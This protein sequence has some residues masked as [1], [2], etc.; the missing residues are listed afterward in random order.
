MTQQISRRRVLQGAGA[1]AL[2]LL[3][4]EGRPAA[5]RASTPASLRAVYHMT[6]PSGWL[7]DPQRPV[8]ADGAYQL[9]YLHSGQNNG[10]GG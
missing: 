5:A 7:C 3:L 2:A 9:Y 10:P 8:T 4:S 1:G 6:P